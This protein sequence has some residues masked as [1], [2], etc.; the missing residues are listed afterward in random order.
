MEPRNRL[1]REA[2]AETLA[3]LGKID[4]ARRT[5]EQ[6]LKDLGDSPQPHGFLYG[7]DYFAGDKAGMAAHARALRNT[8]F[9]LTRQTLD[10][11][12]ATVE[13]RFADARELMKQAVQAAEGDGR[14]G[15]AQNGRA[16]EILNRA[17]VGLT[18]D[19]RAEVARM[20][21]E[22]PNESALVNLAFAL[23]LAG[24]FARARTVAAPAWTTLAGD[25]TASRITRPAFEGLIAL[26][27]GRAAQAVELLKPMEPWEDRLKDGPKGAYVRGLALLAAG[28]ASGAEKAFQKLIDRRGL[29]PFSPTYP[30]AFLGVGR[31]R[32][33]RGDPGGAR[34]AYD[35]FFTLWKNADPDI[36][37]RQQARIEYPKLVGDKASVDSKQ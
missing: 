32:A 36:P 11:Q 34:H 13:G 4:E 30:L 16:S 7:L 37:A 17:V 12:I 28:D 23:V 18:A 5:A 8:P 27:Q 21:A 35:Q 3:A 26:R 33:L 20:L 2:T 25:F 22:K 29:D 10:Y 19:T 31:A 6:E 9:D 14:I 15:L 24:D 1:A